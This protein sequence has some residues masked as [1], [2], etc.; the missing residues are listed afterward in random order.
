MHVREINL[1]RLAHDRIET[2]TL[3]Q[4]PLGLTRDRQG[5]GKPC[6]L[7]GAPILFAEVE[8]DWSDDSSARTLHFHLECH[9]V[10]VIESLS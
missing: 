10:C 3:P 1:Q 7:C 2:G 9:S 8:C 5:S 4:I 6:A